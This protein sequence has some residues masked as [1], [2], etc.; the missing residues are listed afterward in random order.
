MKTKIELTVYFTRFK[1]LIWNVRVKMDVFLSVADANWS[2]MSSKFVIWVSSHSTGWPGKLIADWQCKDGWLFSCPP[3]AP[4]STFDRCAGWVDL[5]QTWVCRWTVEPVCVSN[6]LHGW[7]KVPECLLKILNK[8]FLFCTSFVG[9]NLGFVQ[10]GWI[11]S[12][13]YLCLNLEPVSGSELN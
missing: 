12:A 10:R 2:I 8:L 9:E 1:K 6:V 4:Q 7:N 11:G 13:I 5:N 3:V